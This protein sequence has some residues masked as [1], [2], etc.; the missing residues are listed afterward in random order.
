M[1]GTCRHRVQE[2]VQESSRETQ[3]SAQERMRHKR[4]D[5]NAHAHAHDERERERERT[6]IPN[7]GVTLIDVITNYKKKPIELLFYKLFFLCFL[8][9]FVLFF[10]LPFFW[11][12]LL[13]SQKFESIR[14]R[15]RIA[16]RKNRFDSIRTRQ[17]TKKSTTTQQLTQ[18][19][20]THTHTY[21]YIVIRKCRQLQLTGVI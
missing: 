20:T 10:F 3:S 16:P 19:H 18:T 1:S 11:P 8:L 4:Q 2:R 17:N 15:S 12:L 5:A 7:K 21:I 14:S 9:S 13:C 6:N